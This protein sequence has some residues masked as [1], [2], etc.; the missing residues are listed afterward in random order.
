[1]LQ[2]EKLLN[3]RAEKLKS[4][5]ERQQSREKKTAEVQ[6]EMGV[7]DIKPSLQGSDVQ[8]FNQSKQHYVSPDHQIHVES[9]EELR[10][11]LSES[12]DQMNQ[13]FRK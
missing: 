2:E 8:M 6:N 10:D 13:A 11:D 4:M 3:A 9:A 1:M 5:K 7:I 12:A